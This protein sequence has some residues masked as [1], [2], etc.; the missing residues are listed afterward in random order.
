MNTIPNNNN[1]NNN[2]SNNNNNSSNNNNSNSECNEII[3]PQSS[4]IS[5]VIGTLVV[6]YA[7]FL[8][9]RCNKGFNLGDFILAICC[10]PFYIVY[11]IANPNNCNLKPF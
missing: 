9:F 3:L 8:A 11:K 4:G 6:L 1:S 5:R 10:A 7:L 2:N